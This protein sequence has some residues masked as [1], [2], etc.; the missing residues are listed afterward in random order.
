MK[1][2]RANQQSFVQETTFKINKGNG[3]VY[4]ILIIIIIIPVRPLLADCAILFSGVMCTAPCDECFIN[5]AS[6]SWLP[7]SRTRTMALECLVVANLTRSHHVHQSKLTWSCGGTGTEQKF[8]NGSFWPETICTRHTG[9]G[10]AG[11][12]EKFDCQYQYESVDST[13]LGGVNGKE[14]ECWGFGKLSANSMMGSIQAEQP[15]RIGHEKVHRE[16]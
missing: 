1:V 5:F 13:F 15:T 10:N 9:S 12:S 6:Q 14:A 11:R 7:R 4:I 2:V 8:Q 3:C 16:K